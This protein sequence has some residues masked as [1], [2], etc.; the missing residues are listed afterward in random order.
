V[1]ETKGHE[2]ATNKV[3]GKNKGLA[4]DQGGVTGDDMFTV[5]FMEWSKN[6]ILTDTSQDKVNK[7]C[8]TA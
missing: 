1:A 4:F 8:V 5:L 6:T 2:K 7:W 3:I